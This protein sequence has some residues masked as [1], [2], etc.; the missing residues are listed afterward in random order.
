MKRTND[1]DIRSASVVGL[2]PSLVGQD[3]KNSGSL[4]FE[5]RNESLLLPMY[6]KIDGNQY[7]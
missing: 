2:L 7:G 1:S 5:Q 6:L 4:P 3:T